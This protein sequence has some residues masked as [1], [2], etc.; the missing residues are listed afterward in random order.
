MT[1]PTDSIFS[2]LPPE[3]TLEIFE[4]VLATD[5][6]LYSRIVCKELLIFADE[7][8][9]KKWLELEK[10][11]PPGPINLQ[12]TRINIQGEINYLHLFRELNRTFV[13]GGAPI[14]AGNVRMSQSHFASLQECLRKSLDFSLKILCDKISKQLILFWPAFGSSGTAREWLYDP[15]SLPV[16]STFHTLDL[17]DAGIRF[18]PIEINCFP[19]LRYLNLADNHIESLPPFLGTLKHL[20]V[21]NLKENH[22]ESLPKETADWTHITR[23]DLADNPLNPEAIAILR[24]REENRENRMEIDNA[25]AFEG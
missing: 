10:N 23:I 6:N 5:G 19:N 22:I 4:R 1:A 18:I 3:L 8:I 20:V 15:S 11:P 7:V 2:I 24:Q 16:R 17:S 13:R 14:P 12:S 9:K 21:V 25:H